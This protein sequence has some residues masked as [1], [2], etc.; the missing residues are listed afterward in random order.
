MFPFTTASF[1]RSFGGAG[2]EPGQC[3]PE[4]VCENRG[5]FLVPFFF[6][7]A[8]DAATSA[9][10]WSSPKSTYGEPERPSNLETVWY[11]IRSEPHVR[12]LLKDLLSLGVSRPSSRTIRDVHATREM[13]RT[14]VGS[15][16][17]GYSI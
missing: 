4:Y 11:R 7:F 5:I 13:L 12:V 8:L 9:R 16:L 17:Q 1:V 15:D 2:S 14:S 3:P 6:G 10:G